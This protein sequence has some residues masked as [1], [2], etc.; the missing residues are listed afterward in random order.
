[1]KLK[2]RIENNGEISFIDTPVKLECGNYIGKII[3]SEVD[4]NDSKYLL[5]TIKIK[6]E[7]AKELKEKL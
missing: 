6:D 5:I 4:P 1:M 7:C 2:A 3:K